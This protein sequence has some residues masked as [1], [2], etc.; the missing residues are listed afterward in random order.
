MPV[1]GLRHLIQTTIVKLHRAGGRGGAPHPPATEGP[2]WGMGGVRTDGAAEGQDPRLCNKIT[3][4]CISDP[5]RSA[6]QR[7]KGT[8]HAQE[9]SLPRCYSVA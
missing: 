9:T 5:G 2:H 7:Q 8:G 1:L 4:V 6:G 3:D